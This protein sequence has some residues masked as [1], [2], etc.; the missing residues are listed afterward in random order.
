MSSVFVRP[1][2]LQQFANASCGKALVRKSVASSWV[3]TR[4]REAWLLLMIS[5]THSRAT[6]MC[7]YCFEK[8]S[9]MEPWYAAW[10]SI[11]IIVASRCGVSMSSRKAH[12]CTSCAKASFA[13]ISLASAVEGEVVECLFASHEIVHSPIVNIHTYEECWSLFLALAPKE[14]SQYPRRIKSLFV[15][16]YLSANHFVCTKCL[17]LRSTVLIVVLLRS[18]F[19][20]DT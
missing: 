7:F 18:W 2:S 9:P 20:Y 3:L 1:T 8:F 10:L 14:A 19:P 6:L 5:R 13:A 11:W 16:P 15:P 17:R 12:K 4:W